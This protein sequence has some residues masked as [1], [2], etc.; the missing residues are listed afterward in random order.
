MIATAVLP[1]LEQRLKSTVDEDRVL[2]LVE[3]ALAQH[4]PP[5]PKSFN[6]SING[7][8]PVTIQGYAHH[9]FAPLLRLASLGLDTLIY[10]PAGGGKTTVLRQIAESLG[11]PYYGLSLNTQATFTSLIGYMDGLGRYQSTGFRRWFEAGGVFALEEAGLASGNLA[12]SLNTALDNGIASFPDSVAPIER[13]KNTWLCGT[14]NSA[15]D[16]GD[17]LYSAREPQDAAFRERFCFFKWEYDQRLEELLTLGHS[18]LPEVHY[19]WTVKVS[20]KEW[21]TRVH[22]LRAALEPSR[23]AG[24]LVV[25]PRAA[26]K[27]CK[28]ADAGF[29][30]RFIEDALIWKGAD[31]DTQATLIR[32]AGVSRA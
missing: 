21:V 24:R 9:Q 4:P 26:I 17:A 1:L 19:D 27:G 29:S 14:D 11:R 16:G 30:L 32:H 18:D 10:G 8:E 22:A 31:E 25:S 28:L 15:L 13:A 3:Q 5:P 23:L 7:G 2:E 6:V 20:R 12:C